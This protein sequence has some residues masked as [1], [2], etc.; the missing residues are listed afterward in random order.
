MNNAIELTHAGD[1]FLPYAQ[2]VVRNWRKARQEIALPQGFTGILTIAS[3]PCLW[4][5]YLLGRMEAFQRKVSH[6]AFNAVI[7]DSRRL[8]EKLEARQSVVEGKSVSVRVD[9][10]GSRNIKK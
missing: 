7:G 1:A 9:H 3:P 5:A 2:T 10:G 4:Y 6:V 8:I